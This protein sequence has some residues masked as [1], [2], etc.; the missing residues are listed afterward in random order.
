[1]AE[2]SCFRAGSVHSIAATEKYGAIAE[3]ISKAQALSEV[4]DLGLFEDCVVTREKSGST[5]I[6]RGVAVAHGKTPLVDRVIVSLGI[7]RQGIEF[8]SPDGQ[9]VHLLFLVA[10]PPDKSSEYLMALST[11]ASICKVRDLKQELLSATTIEAG[12]FV[13]DAFGSVLHSRC[14]R[15]TGSPVLSGLL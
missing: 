9:P 10:S 2:P 5:G 13:V 8:G 15:L 14:S 7:S 4:A 3:L 12:R 1:M 11:I 6:G